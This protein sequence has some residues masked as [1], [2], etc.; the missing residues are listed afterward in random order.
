[1][2]E[3]R[4]YEIL[5]KSYLGFT[6]DQALLARWNADRNLLGLISNQRQKL[7]ESLSTSSRRLP[8]FWTE[9]FE[10]ASELFM[11]RDFP[12]IYLIGFPRK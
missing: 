7:V 12:S 1:M 4:K 9:V 2:D 5:H 3:F 8:E 6:Q 10:A 11:A